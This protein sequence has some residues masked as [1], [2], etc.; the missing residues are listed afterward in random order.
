MKFETKIIILAIILSM[1]N[2]FWL[3]NPIIGTLAVATYFVSLGLIIGRLIDKNGTLFEQIFWGT[4]SLLLVEIILN[5]ALYYIVGITPATVTVTLLAPL[6]VLIFDRTI[7]PIAYH[8]SHITYRISKKHVLLISLVILFDASLL[9]LL[10]THRILDVVPSPWMIFTYRF[11]ALYALATIALF[12]TVYKVNNIF[13]QWALTALHL[14]ITFGIAAIMYPL[15]FGFDGFIHRATETW[16]FE[17]GS[18]TP[19]RPFYI[20]Q[21]SI[22][23]WLAHLTRIPIFYLDVYLVPLLASL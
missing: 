11:F 5:T 22:V 13:V 14:F 6:A 4:L 7:S 18:I 1:L 12:I 21:Y 9:Y 10:Y 23:V 17:H 15:G 2:L 19:L 20:G 8:V 16:I 3:H